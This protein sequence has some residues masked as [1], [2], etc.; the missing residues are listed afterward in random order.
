[1]RCK[2]LSWRLPEVRRPRL[3]EVVTEAPRGFYLWLDEQ[4]INQ[5]DVFKNGRAETMA[6]LFCA[7]PQ[8]RHDGRAP[9]PSLPRNADDHVAVA[10]ARASH[11]LQPIEHA[12]R[13]CN[14]IA[15]LA[16]RANLS[17]AIPWAASMLDKGSRDDLTWPRILPLSRGTTLPLVRLQFGRVQRMLTMP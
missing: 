10:L 17:P 6:R 8:R 12:A 11:R 13:Q 5:I 9:R 3:N 16:V 1:M 4:T 14:Q 15:A 7:W 2:R